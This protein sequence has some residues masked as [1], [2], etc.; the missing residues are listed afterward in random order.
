MTTCEEWKHTPDTLLLKDFDLADDKKQPSTDEAELA[1][2]QEDLPAYE[3]ASI[4][5]E[6]LLGLVG[7][8]P[9]DVDPKGGAKTT[10]EHHF[11]TD[12]IQLQASI[13]SHPHTTT[14]FLQCVIRHFAKTVDA[15]LITLSQHDLE[16]L[17][18]HLKKSEKVPEADE[19]LTQSAD[20]SYMS[21]LF[22][23]SPI[24]APPTSSGSET[25]DSEAEKQRD[26]NE[27]P[28]AGTYGESCESSGEISTLADLNEVS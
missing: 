15:D 1:D 12:I 22:G 19:S 4:L 14:R 7:S 2:R 3:M 24:V 13:K 27:R 28:D 25:S 11:S 9:P 21:F 5:F 10:V 26:Q 6:P 17:A 16:D 18:D 20:Q 8:V 23:S